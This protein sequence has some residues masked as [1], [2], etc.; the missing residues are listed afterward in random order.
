MWHCK[1]DFEDFYLGK[2]RCVQENKITKVLDLQ[3]NCRQLKEKKG[4]KKTQHKWKCLKI[5]FLVSLDDSMGAWER[6]SW[7]WCHVL[8]PWCGCVL[9]APLP[10]GGKELC[11]ML[12]GIRRGG[13]DAAGLLSLSPVPSNLVPPLPKSMDPA[14]LSPLWD[15][16][17][18]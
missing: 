12:V 15:G 3:R 11:A 9:P 16:V 8:G 5:R 18:Y 6:N 14:T 2:S 13:R 10:L 1:K 7:L 17:C 4:K